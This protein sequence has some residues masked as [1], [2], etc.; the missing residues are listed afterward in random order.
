[1]QICTQHEVMP[2]I[3]FHRLNQEHL[4]NVN[5]EIITYNVVILSGA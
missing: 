2:V 5:M 4:L 1:M 3:V